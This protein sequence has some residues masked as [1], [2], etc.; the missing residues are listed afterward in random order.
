MTST[1]HGVATSITAFVGRARRGPV[2]HPVAIASF[3]DFDRVFGDLGPDGSLGYAVSDFYRQGGSV[4]VVV[5]ADSPH[6]G[7]TAVLTLGTAGDDQL[8]LRAA[9]PGAWGSRLTARTDERGVL[10]VSDTA[11]GLSESFADLS[12]VE[13]TSS[14]V[15]VHTR[16]QRVPPAQTAVLTPAVDDGGQAG[17][18]D[19]G[20]YRRALQALRRADLVNLLV[21]PG[22][23][24][25][26]VVAA[27]IAFAEERRAVFL[28]DPPAGWSTVDDAVA[29]AAAFPRSANAAVYFPRIRRPGPLR[30]ASGAVAGV[31]ARTD[32][33]RG[34]WTSPAGVE[35]ELKG[36]AE[37]DLPLTDAEGGRLNPLGV[38]CLRSFPGTGPVLWG[39]RTADVEWRYLAVRRTALFLA[40]SIARGLRRA[41]FEPND[42]PLWASIRADIGAFLHELFGRGAFAGTTPRDAYFVRCDSETTTRA[43]I[44]SGVV[45][46]VV[47]F[48]PSR[49]AEFVLLRL[50]QPAGQA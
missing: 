4:A 30:A 3:A 23:L 44:D 20:A 43:D 18:V 19:A 36:V 48:A 39:A 34:V 42:E 21:V 49:P 8:V 45:N 6:E 5:R 50:Q 31:I 12:L 16:P 14:L 26:E 25:P 17:P 10:V 47:G 9:S 32:V 37:L 40:E 28:A 11:T 33:A 24:P 46:V 13:A 29:A 27:A 38:N 2:D 7:D 22:D 41:T 35:A 15:R 1:I